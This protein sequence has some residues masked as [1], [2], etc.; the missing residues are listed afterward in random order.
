M[1]DNVL[2]F[3]YF[4]REI[5]VWPLTWRIGLNELCCQTNNNNAVMMI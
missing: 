5:G 1:S 4:I 2:F 3:I